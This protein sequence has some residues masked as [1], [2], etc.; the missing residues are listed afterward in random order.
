MTP[1]RWPTYDPSNRGQGVLV[2]YTGGTIGSVP[3]DPTDPKSPLVVVDWSEFR[4]RTSSL[5]ERL[6]DG[7][8]NYRY[9]GFNVDGCSIEPLDSCNIGPE[10]WIQIARIIEQNYARYTGFVV[11]HGTDTMVYTASA[12]SFM[13]DN[14]AKPVILTGAL[15]SHLTNVRNDGLQNLLTALILANPEHSG[16]PIVPEVGVFFNRYLLRGNRARKVNASGFDAFQSP[17]YPPLAVAGESIV[18]DRRVI[19]S[20]APH[21]SLRLRTNLETNVVAISFFPGIQHSSL[22]ADILRDE[23][24]RGVVLMAY[25]AGTVPATPSVLREIEAA[26]RRGVIALAV[27]QCGGGQVDLERY[28]AST[29]LLDAGVLSGVDITPEAALVKLMVLL[30][31]KNLS[32]GDIRNLVRQDIAGE[33]TVA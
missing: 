29:R 17:N 3:C 33:Q 22:L 31:D 20:V 4:R 13:L 7:S 16:L 32:L 18:V 27:T 23:N 28:E 6:A 10:H 30:G 25:G 14:L 9:I 5:S 19:R 15:R 26:V 21:A 2:I 1:G 24:L 11:L 8:P 12:L